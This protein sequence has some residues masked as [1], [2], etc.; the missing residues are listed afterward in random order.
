MT[1]EQENLLSQAVLDELRERKYY[2]TES[3]DSFFTGEI[4]ADYRDEM[5]EKTAGEILKTDDPAF[6][7]EEMMDEWYLSTAYDYRDDLKKEIMA[8]VANHKEDVFPAN[9]YD[10]A[11]AFIDEFIDEHVWF[12]A[13]RDHFLDQ[14]FCVNI[15]VDA[16]DG[17]YDYTLNSVY[18][19]W[20]GRAKDRIHDCAGIVWLAKSQGYNKTQL[21][22]ALKSGDMREPHGFLQS[23]RVELANLPSHMST[24]TFLTKMTL[25]QLIELNQVIIWREK[26]G[27]CYD[28]REYPNCGY[29]LLGKETMTGLYDP[30]AGGGSVLDVE[31]EK[32][33]RLPIKFIRCALTDEGHLPCEYGIGEVYGMCESAWKPSYK[34]IHVPKKVTAAA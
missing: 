3:G 17:N 23:M 22:N 11:E 9:L 13:P 28:A 32:D 21:W 6:A 16:G 12:E 29:I 2:L 4:Y 10:E 14:E 5:D 20:N 31:L 25:R 18:P 27:R 7:F 30:W 19:Y 33:V 15:M 1:I 24:V 8:A 26:Q 34:G